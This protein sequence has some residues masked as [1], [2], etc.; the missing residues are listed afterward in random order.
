MQKGR[1]G[2]ESR[3]A[4][5]N[6]LLIFTFILYSSSTHTPQCVLL[7]RNVKFPGLRDS[8][9]FETFQLQSRDSRDFPRL[10]L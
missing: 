4:G 3:V 2:Q 5:K 8:E 7:I 9:T 10:L 1:V 6:D